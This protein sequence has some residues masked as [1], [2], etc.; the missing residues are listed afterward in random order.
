MNTSDIPEDILCLP[1]KDDDLPTLPIWIRSLLREQR[2]NFLRA[3]TSAP[4]MVNALKT[5]STDEHLF[6][7]VMSENNA[8]LFV[9]AADGTWKPL[10]REA[11]QIKEHISLIEVSSDLT[12][13]LSNLALQAALYRISKQLDEIA[14]GVNEIKNIITETQ[15]GKVKGASDAL[16]VALS[17][18]DETQRKIQSLSACSL[19]HTQLGGLI[20]QMKAAINKMASQETR[21]FDGWWGNKLD[22]ADKQY[23]E[24]WTDFALAVEALRLITMTYMQFGEI[25]AAQETFKNFNKLMTSAGIDVAAE[26]SRLLPYV[27]ADKAPERP[28]RLFIEAMP[29]HSLLLEHLTGD[30]SLPDLAISFSIREV[31]P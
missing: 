9:Q 19:A 31:L 30:H 15:R 17:L 24:V 14:R 3:L 4:D 25:Q 27:N 18:N 2:E 21:F 22:D 28:F 12:P 23:Q 5:L 10:L 26:R 29:L 7:V 6:R 11:G 13:A 8:H 16:K 1:E 20:G